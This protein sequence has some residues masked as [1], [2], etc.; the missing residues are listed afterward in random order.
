VRESNRDRLV[1]RA[2]VQ[3]VRVLPDPSLFQRLVYRDPAH[4]VPILEAVSQIGYLNPP[5]VDSPMIQ[6]S[7]A[8]R[9]AFEGVIRTGPHQFAMYGWALLPDGRPADAVVI[10]RDGRIEALS[11]RTIGRP[12]RP[13]PGWDLPVTQRLAMPGAVYN[14]FAYDTSTR[15]AYQLQGSVRVGRR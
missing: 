15:R 13:G 1:A 2:A 14:A 11:E 9:G 8:T 4:A 5:L 12:D 6:S 10:A 3:F 7:G